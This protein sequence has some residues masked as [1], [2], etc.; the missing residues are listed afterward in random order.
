[1]LVLCSSCARHVRSDADTCPF[2]SASTSSSAPVIAMAPA[3]RL[4]RAAIVTLGALALG[5]CNDAKSP[6]QVTVDPVE[7][8]AGPTATATA[9]ATTTATAPPP[10]PTDD[11][12][13]Q[14][15]PYGAPP[16]PEEVV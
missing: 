4:G 14:A 10:P 13:N 6:D 2:C 5:A 12:R 9:S 16:V 11:W 8:G 3:A 1:M 7:A 15:K